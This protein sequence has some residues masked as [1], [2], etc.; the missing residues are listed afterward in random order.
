MI[1]TSDISNEIAKKKNRILAIA[2]AVPAMPPKPNTADTNAIT[3]NINAQRIIIFSLYL[4]KTGMKR[5][6]IK[7]IYY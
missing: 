2:A 5:D 1:K 4:F 3:K 7:R 6:D